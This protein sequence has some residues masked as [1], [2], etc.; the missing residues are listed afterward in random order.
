MRLAAGVAMAVT[1]GHVEAVEFI[2]DG[3]AQATAVEC[4]HGVFLYAADERSKAH[5]STD[6]RALPHAER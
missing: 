1:D 3:L 5:V 2:G 4:A 6:N